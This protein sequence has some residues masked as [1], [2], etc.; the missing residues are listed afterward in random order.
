MS[1]LFVDVY[2]ACHGVRRRL[3]SLPLQTIFFTSHLIFLGRK[4]YATS[5]A[6]VAEIEDSLGF[7]LGS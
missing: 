3:G 4:V 6:L 7:E 5:M 1:I 2:S